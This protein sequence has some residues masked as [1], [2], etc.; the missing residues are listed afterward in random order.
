MDIDIERQKR[1]LKG[2]P[3]P[4]PGSGG[5]PSTFTKSTISKHETESRAIEIV[6]LYEEE[7]GRDPKDVRKDGVGYDVDSSD[8]KIEV[9]SFKG[10]P[11]AIELYE[12]EY[13]AA[14]VHRENF[15]IYIVYNMLK[16]SQPKIEIIKDPLNSV[17]F[18]AEKRTAKNWKKSIIDEEVDVLC[19][20]EEK[21]D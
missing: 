9:K 7:M 1:K 13:E 20:T 2:R 17:V 8:R 18:V 12:S 21:A 15:Y 14:K 6:M 11:G 4:V 19:K 3:K 16:G 5:G 10:S